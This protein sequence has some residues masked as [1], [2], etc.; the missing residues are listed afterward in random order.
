MTNNIKHMSVR[1][2]RVKSQKSSKLLRGFESNLLEYM[3]V[4]LSIN[5]Q[6]RVQLTL[7][8]AFTPMANAGKEPSS[9]FT[10]NDFWIFE[11]GQCSSFENP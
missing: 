2:V 7:L 8:H 1:S 4:S 9:R 5:E 10:H 6:L 3:S 11:E